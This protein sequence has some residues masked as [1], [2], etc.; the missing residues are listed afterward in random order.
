MYPRE[1][2]CIAD[3][4]ESL[5]HDTSLV[6]EC[7]GTPPHVNVYGCVYDIDTE[8]LWTLVTLAGRTPAGRARQ[9]AALPVPRT[10][11]AS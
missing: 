2:I 8:E 10:K 6:R 3:Y 5:R 11:S 9:A 4:A 1:S 7:P